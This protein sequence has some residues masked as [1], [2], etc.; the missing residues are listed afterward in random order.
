MELVILN[1]SVCRR[2]SRRMDDG[3][4]YVLLLVTFAIIAI[5][6]SAAAIV[7]ETGGKRA[8]EME[9]IFVGSEFARAI[10]SYYQVQLGGTKRYPRNLQ[11][12]LVDDRF[13]TIV[14]HLRKIYIDPMTGR[15]QWGLIEAPGGGIMGIH[16]LSDGRP[17]LDFQ[18][19]FPSQ[20]TQ[21]KESYSDWKF[22]YLP[23]ALK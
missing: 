1:G 7:Y 14:R 4:T 3:F 20:A 23:N 12:L 6:A 2:R 19:V 21:A 15:A 16:S 13:P 17:L 9:L 8:H 10:K 22:I 5:G 18:T 11:D